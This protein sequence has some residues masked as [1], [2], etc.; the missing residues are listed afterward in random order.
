MKPACGLILIVFLLSVKVTFGQKEN[1]SVLDKKISIEAKNE[2]VA[3]V[4]DKIT[5]QSHVFF[6]YNAT[7]INAEKKIDA[8]LTDKTI[9]EILNVL[10][11]SKYFYQVLDDQ[12]VIT[13]Q[14]SEDE[15]KKTDEMTGTK[16]ATIVF[17]GKVIDIGEKDALPYSGISVQRSNIGTISNIDGEFELKIPGTMINDTVVVS[18]L[19]YKQFLLPVSKIDKDA[20]TIYLQ[21]TIFQFQEV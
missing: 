7:L 6:S 4:L 16:P 3:L 17:R 12:I 10:F 11:E 15:K 1:N 18:C 8:S 13:T 5:S 19:G 14:N 9:R 21:P 2:T 20:V